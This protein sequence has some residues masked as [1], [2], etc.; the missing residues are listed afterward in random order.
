MFKAEEL[1][2]WLRDISVHVKEPLSIYLVGGGAMSFHK[3]KDI[4]KDIDIVALNKNKYQELDNA[5]TQAGFKLATDLDNFYLT[6]MSVYMRGDSRIDVFVKQVGKMLSLTKGILARAKHFKDFGNLSVH[7]FS[8]EDIFLFKSMTTREGDLKDC[9]TLI[10]SGLDYDVIY[11]EI[12]EQ[13]T[14]EQKWFFWLFERT[15]A[16]ENYSGRPIPLKSKLLKLI[17]DHW[18]ERP[19]SFMEDVDNVEKHLPKESI[20]GLSSVN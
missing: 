15:C 8:Q 12:L 3:L 16:Y 4:T 19:K 20:K 9:T 10:M 11:E 17:K 13:S 2:A 1:E 7:L 14:K 6:A 5:I 18:Q